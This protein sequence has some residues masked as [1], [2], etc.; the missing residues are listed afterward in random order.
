M[1]KYTKAQQKLRRAFWGM[2]C[3]AIATILAWILL[4]ISIYNHNTNILPNAIFAAVM[5]LL[6]VWNIISIDKLKKNL[7]KYPKP[8]MQPKNQ[9]TKAQ[10]QLQKQ[11]KKGKNY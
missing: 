6:F 10:A 8:E 11:K 2:I 3:G 1:D 9:K 5:S 4:T 7:K